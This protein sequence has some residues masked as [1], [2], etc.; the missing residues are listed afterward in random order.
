VTEPSSKFKAPREILGI[1]GDVVAVVT[2]RGVLGPIAV[3]W[4]AGETAH[5]RVARAAPGRGLTDEG[6]PEAPATEDGPIR[7]DRGPVGWPYDQVDAQTK[8]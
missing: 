2:A 1:S 3:G 5:L 8:Q 6:D 7:L 4:V